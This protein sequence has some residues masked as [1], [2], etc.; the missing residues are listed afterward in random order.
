LNPHSGCF[1]LNA[2]QMEHWAAQR[3]F[4][5]RDSRLIGPLE[6]AATLGV[7]RTFKIYRPAPINA[8]FLEVQHF[9][10]DYLRQLVR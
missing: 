2:R 3:H 6:T 9:G 7:L 5:D 8:D 1:F 10:T 4:L